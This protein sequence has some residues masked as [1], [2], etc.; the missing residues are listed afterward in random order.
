MREL[1][2]VDVGRRVPGDVGWNT[3][4]LVEAVRG[5]QTLWFDPKVPLAEDRRRIA[6]ALEQVARQLLPGGARA[7]Q[8]SESVIWADVDVPVW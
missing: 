8:Y 1:D 2:R 7:N 6:G 5:R 3:I 4:E